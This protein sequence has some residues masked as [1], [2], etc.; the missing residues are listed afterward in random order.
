MA[1]LLDQD[2]IHC[3]EFPEP[4]LSGGC[5]LDWLEAWCEDAEP[6]PVARRPGM[7]Q[8]EGIC[9][10]LDRMLMALRARVRQHPVLKRLLLRLLAPVLPQIS[11]WANRLDGPAYETWFARWQ[12]SDP[13][14]DA[15][16]RAALDHRAPPF[17]VVVADGEAGARTRGSLAAQ[18]AGRWTAISAESIT[19]TDGNAGE[20]LLHCAA[21]GGYLLRL[22]GG[23]C[24][25]RHAIAVLGNAAC[26]GARP[27]VLY[28]DEDVQ[29][30]TGIHR[31]PWFKVAFDPDR[32]LQQDSLGS[33]VAY[34]AALLVRHGLSSLRGHALAL[35]A[36]RRVNVNGEPAAD[37]AIHHVPAVLVH[38]PGQSAPWRS[39][40]DA[41]AV[42]AALDAAG[43]GAVIQGDGTER[44]LR[45]AWPLRKSAPL[46][47]IIIPTRDK[48]ELLRPCLDGLL[49]RTSYPEFEVLV[50]DNDSTEPALHALLDRYST[51]PRLRVLR[52][53]GAFNYSAIN[54][55]AA[56]AARGEV[57]LLLNNDTEVLHAD[58]LSE[59]VSQAIRAGVGAV[60]ARLLFARGRVQHAGVVI[61]MGGVAGHE[62]LFQRREECGPQDALRVVRTVSAVT[63]ACLAVRRDTFFEVG[64][65]DEERLRIA[66]NDVD[67][68]LKL[69]RAGY[70]NLV[71]PHAELLHKESASR[72]SDRARAQR[73]RWESERATMLAAWSIDHKHDPYFS[74]SLSLETAFPQLAEPPRSKPAWMKSGASVHP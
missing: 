6:G 62:F 54:N 58:W 29:D 56:A 28:A 31:D 5:R 8:S 69:R 14:H 30:D 40:T 32:L 55:R 1:K 20:A 49:L 72:G 74:P 46:V 53:G 27:L 51:D 16:I 15:T 35:A 33:A 18:V 3:V 37:R 52:H 43:E 61:G 21:C 48:S 22:E 36:T 23:E 2:Q 66:Y 68:C 65:F 38:R 67:F 41:N 12:A 39:A 64:G 26:Q 60:G 11:L 4:P 19:D 47:S 42:A 44:P 71:T 13:S 59:M 73:T 50:V 34:D 25:A 10:V 24:L 9:T 63:A 17:L 7:A 45:I 70:R 57:L